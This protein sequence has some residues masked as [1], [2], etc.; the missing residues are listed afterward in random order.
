MHDEGPRI[1]VKM[2][3]RSIRRTGSTRKIIVM[4]SDN[5]DHDVI[6][7]L[8]REDNV[9]T[10]IVPALIG[11]ARDCESS[12]MR[13]HAWKLTDYKRLIL[14]TPH[15]LVNTNMDELFLCGKFCAVCM[16][17][18]FFETNI[19][20][21]EPNQETYLS[22]LRELALE[23]PKLKLGPNSM[24]C[25]SEAKDFFFLNFYN[26]EAAP[27]FEPS[28]GQSDAELMR[29]D[30]PVCLDHVVYYEHLDWKLIRTP[31]YKDIE[32]P[33]MALTFPPP[34]YPW[35]YYISI[36]TDLHWYYMEQRLELIPEGQYTGD[37]IV[38]C[39]LI[40]FAY[41]IGEYV[42]IANLN[43]RINTFP[44]ATENAVIR[45]KLTSFS[46]RLLAVHP[47]IVTFLY[48]T[49]LYAVI[50]IVSALLIVNTTIPKHAWPMWTV[51]SS[52]LQYFFLRTILVIFHPL[53]AYEKTRRK[54]KQRAQG[55]STV[56]TYDNEVQ[57]TSLVEGGNAGKDG[58]NEDITT[59]DEN[60]T[61][62]AKKR[63]RS[64]SLQGDNTGGIKP[65]PISIIHRY[66]DKSSFSVWMQTLRGTAATVFMLWCV[67]VKQEWYTQFAAK[68]LVLFMCIFLCGIAFMVAYKK[69]FY[70]LYNVVHT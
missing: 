65:L 68:F 49:F 58:E 55:Y 35:Q 18:T 43:N 31:A 41:L 37:L 13:I 24:A 33:G 19:F 62:R 42:V 44:S 27:L 60:A 25:S 46:S 26:L 69:L 67:V 36:Y 61:R 8:E 59:D 48:G 63:M 1:G 12:F 6:R 2:V 22:L 39:I 14:A 38:H 47:I 40:I 51:I 16:S 10:M 23:T 15:T 4:V 7:M 17:Y 9:E 66:T 56:S 5:T 70:A 34:F 45:G 30:V 50:S 32:I 3:I 54:K 52:M 57:M 53:F 28:R 21:I 29:M 11:G 64:L 20:V